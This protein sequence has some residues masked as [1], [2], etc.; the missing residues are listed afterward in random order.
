MSP[1][2]SLLFEPFKRGANDR[3]GLGLGL[4]I[5]RV[6]AEA[7]GG[8][9]SVESSEER[10]TVFMLRLPRAASAQDQALAYG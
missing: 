2:R 4:Y 8:E 10:G 1:I 6:I 3:A 7:H 5:V 9:V